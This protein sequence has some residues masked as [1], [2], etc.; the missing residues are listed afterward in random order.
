[1]KAITQKVKQLIRTFPLRSIGVDGP[2]IEDL[3]IETSAET[4]ENELQLYRGIIPFSI[5]YKEEN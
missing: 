5:N 3:T 1:M 4:Y 2:Y